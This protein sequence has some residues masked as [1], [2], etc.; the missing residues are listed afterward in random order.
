MVSPT[1]KKMFLYWPFRLEFNTFS[2]L[3]LRSDDGNTYLQHHSLF[4]GCLNLSY[5][6]KVLILMYLLFVQLRKDFVPGHHFQQLVKLIELHSADKFWLFCALKSEIF[7]FKVALFFIYVQDQINKGQKV[8]LSYSCHQ[9]ESFCHS[10][11]VLEQKSESLPESQHRLDA[12]FTTNTEGDLQVPSDSS[13]DVKQQ[14]CFV[15][16]SRH[17]Q[18]F[19]LRRCLPHTL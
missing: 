1:G 16:V 7:S 13:Q 14:E 11:R 19:L 10:I 3:Q 2:P 17:R 15:C 4:T 12:S 9:S 6:Y 18:H 5:L 8:T